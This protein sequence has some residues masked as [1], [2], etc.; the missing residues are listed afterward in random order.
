MPFVDKQALLHFK[1]NIISDPSKL[2]HSWSVSSDCCSAW[3]GVRVQLLR[4]ELSMSHVRDLFQ[5]M[6]SSLTLSLRFC[7]L[8]ENKLRGTLPASLGPAPKDRKAHFREQQI[9]R[10]TA[11]NHGHL[12]TL[13]DIFFSNNHFTG[14]IPSSF[15]NL[16]NLQTLDLSRNRLSGQIPPQLA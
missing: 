16:H 10:K 12:A 13:T 14:K 4:Q 6:T 2:L 8:S 1:H 11:R 3:E 5:T 9:F 7:Q 15:G